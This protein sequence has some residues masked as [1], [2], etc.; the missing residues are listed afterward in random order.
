MNFPRFVFGPLWVL[1]SV[2][3][4]SEAK[5][6]LLDCSFKDHYDFVRISEYFTGKEN[7]SGR[8]IERT[9][10]TDRTG[11]YFWVEINS[12]HRV[13][14]DDAQKLVLRILDSDSIDFKTYEFPI[15]PEACRR[16]KLLVGI[17][18]KDWPS[19][20]ARLVAWHMEIVS[21]KGRLVD[22]TES[23]LWSHKNKK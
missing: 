8:V 12:I 1:I 6:Q 2:P 20:K 7:T 14:A 18:G 17:T 5:L 15:S 23:Y 11:L 13:S 16:G 22:S 19:K 10:E 21:S 3:I 4:S 9:Q